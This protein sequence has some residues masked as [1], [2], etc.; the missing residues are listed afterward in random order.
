[1]QY[2]PL[3]AGLGVSGIL[4]LLFIASYKKAKSDEALV[5]SGLGKQPKIIVGKA[6]F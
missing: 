5:V 4:V 6:G 3:L 1:M 2:I